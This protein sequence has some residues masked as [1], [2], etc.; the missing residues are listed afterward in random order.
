MFL[1]AVTYLALP[2]FLIIFTF[3]SAPFVFLGSIALVTLIVSLYKLPLSKVQ[4]QQVQQLVRHWPLLV[5][6]LV[7]SYL[8]IMHPFDGN[9][10]RRYFATF[11]L[12][13]E[14]S[15][16]PIVEM[17]GKFYY[18]RYYLAYYMVP[19]LFAKIFGVHLFMPA[20]FVW[21]ALGIFIAM[22]LFFHNFHKAW[23]LFVAALVFLFFSGLDIVGASLTGTLASPYTYWLD[24]WA[25]A[26]LF[27]ILSNISTLQGAPQH[28]LAAYLSTCL[29]LFN[30][31][32]AV[33]Y[34]A[35]I[36]V[37]TTMWSPFCAFGLLPIAAYSLF[38]EGIKTSLTLK[39]LFVAPLL[40]IPILLYLLSGTERIPF[41]FVWEKDSFYFSN[42]VLFCVLEFLII[43]AVFYFIL[44]K[45][46]NLIAVTAGFLSLLCVYKIGLY[47]DLLSRGAMPAVCVMSVWMFRSLMCSKGYWKK[48]I[49][50]Y[51]L[52]SSFYEVV[53]FTV[54]L[55]EPMPKS[56]IKI[57]FEEFLLLRPEYKDDF[58]SLFFIETSN[59]VKVRNIP[60]IRGLS[61]QGL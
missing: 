30:R 31:R 59:V 44:K 27:V 45:E 13:T 21:T 55:R 24:W 4:T 54:A 58:R 6:A 11:N 7:V 2:V 22:S 51:L 19:A 57:T 39:N 53:K 48:I 47:N 15:W 29:L 9:D 26:E 25:G 23:H 60:I 49:I 32:L 56:D 8:C 34:G 12:L 35:V 18:L 41:M 17:E 61:A 40:A 28:A 52:V 10:W 38:K 42:F 43:L 50:T 14:N 46:R 3:F 1:L 5:V 37:L 33:K 16:P 20:L 36:I